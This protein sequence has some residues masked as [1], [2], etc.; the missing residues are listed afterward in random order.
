MTLSTCM[1]YRIVFSSH[2]ETSDKEP[3]HRREWLR[4]F[5]CLVYTVALRQIGH[6]LVKRVW[7]ST[8]LHGVVDGSYL[9]NDSY[10]ERAY[11]E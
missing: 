8:L 10:S 3:V 1:R 11:P 7:P 4:D 6:G 2:S 5:A 9:A